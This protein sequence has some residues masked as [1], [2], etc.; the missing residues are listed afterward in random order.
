MMRLP[1][2]VTNKFGP[3]LPPSPLPQG[4]VPDC[5]I[6]LLSFFGSVCGTNLLMTFGKFSFNHTHRPSVTRFKLL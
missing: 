6:I 1:A 3:P 4:Q 5:C 2:K